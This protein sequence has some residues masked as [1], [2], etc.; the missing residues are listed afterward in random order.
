[1]LLKLCNNISFFGGEG[2]ELLTLY[3]LESSIIDI[4][5]IFVTTNNICN[6]LL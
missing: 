3:K 1:M 6:H 2:W 5:P 4:T